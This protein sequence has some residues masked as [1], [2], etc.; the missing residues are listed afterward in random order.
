MP[1]RDRRSKLQLWLS[2]CAVS[3]ASSPG[4]REAAMEAGRLVLPGSSSSSERTYGL[5]SSIGCASLIAWRSGG[6]RERGERRCAQLHQS[7]PLHYQRGRRGIRPQEGERGGPRREGRR[8]VAPTK[9]T[10][11]E[12]ALLRKT[13][14]LAAGQVGAR[15]STRSRAPPKPIDAGAAPPP[16]IKTSINK[17]RNFS[18]QHNVRPRLRQY[19][20]DVGRSELGRPGRP[21]RPGEPRRP[22]TVRSA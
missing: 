20:Y 11:H 21:A 18:C 22:L 1:K 7:N 16:S 3:A 8:A 2:G 12:G 17:R 10:L 5:L 19:R 15:R 9:A 13:R 6:T 14:V 4:G